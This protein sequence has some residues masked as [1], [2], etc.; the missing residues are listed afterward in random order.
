MASGKSA[1]KRLKAL[2]K[3]IPDDRIARVTMKALERHGGVGGDY[4]IATIGCEL[5]QKALEVSILSRF[6]PLED[7]ERSRIFSYDNRGPLS[8]FSA[9][10]KI[11][12]ALRLFGPKTAEDL[13]T[14]RAIRNAFAHSIELLDFDN[15][16]VTVLCEG[17]HLF[18]TLTLLT[19]YS[20]DASPRTR[21][22]EVTFVLAERL[23]RLLQQPKNAL[24]E[25][26]GTLLM[27]DRLLP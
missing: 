16:D 2:A 10:I 3:Q 12:R 1:S 6:G 11:A 15:A 18:G 8:D 14:I 21:Y 7:T 19:G 26:V 27:K 13:E 20:S 24:A 17:L 5:V 25:Y 22:I 9:R 23:K 4:A